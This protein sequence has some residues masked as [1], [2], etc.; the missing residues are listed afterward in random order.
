MRVVAPRDERE[1]GILH[2]GNKA[3]AHQVPASPEPYR[4]EIVLRPVEARGVVVDHGGQA[5][6]LVGFLTRDN[7]CGG[8][9]I[10]LTGRALG[11]LLLLAV[12]DFRII[13]FGT[14]RPVLVTP[15]RPTLGPLGK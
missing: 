13:I 1:T 11:R 3:V 5:V 10:A 14:D 2:V 7:L 12:V 6:V 15:S 9:V 8:A 4:G